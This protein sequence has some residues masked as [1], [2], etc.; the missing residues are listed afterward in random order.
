MGARPL[1]L[2]GIS[3]G[4]CAVSLHSVRLFDRNARCRI[5]L[6]T[7]KDLWGLA[8]ALFLLCIIERDKIMNED[9]FQFVNV[10]S[11]RALLT[12]SRS[13]KGLTNLSVFELVSAYG[14]VGLSLGVSNV[15]FSSLFICSLLLMSLT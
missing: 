5:G 11:M 14:T 10:F 4:T 12:S 7:L 13:I 9:Q 8:T 15:S 1:V 3:L 6:T 2:E